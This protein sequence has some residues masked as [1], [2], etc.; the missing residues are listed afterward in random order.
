MRFSLQDIKKHVQKRG[1]EL[2]VSLH[3]LRPGEMRAEIARL[4]DYH[5]KLLGQPQRQFSDD[6]VR[7]LV[8]DYRMAHCLA[9]TLSRWYNRRACDW[10]EVPPVVPVCVA[11]QPLELSARL[12]AMRNVVS[13]IF[14][15]LIFMCSTF[16]SLGI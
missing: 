11:L 10:D 1:G 6:D 12:I 13:C 8:G 9:A 15:R 4:I 5:E 16:L 2:T 7:A 3:F 14:V